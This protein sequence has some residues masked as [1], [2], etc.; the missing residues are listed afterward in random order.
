MG[1][2][3]P[4]DRLVSRVGVDARD[5]GAVDPP[6]VE[7]RAIEG[8]E[9]LP[10]DHGP[11]AGHGAHVMAFEGHHPTGPGV[12]HTCRRPHEHVHGRHHGKPRLV[13]H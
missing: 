1:L 9:A 2:G 13:Q 8:H 11:P 4:H 10:V 5:P 7:S 6:A 12:D 3:R